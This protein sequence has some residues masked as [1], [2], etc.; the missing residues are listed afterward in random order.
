MAIFKFFFSNSAFGNQKYPRCIARRIIFYIQLILTGKIKFLIC[1]SIS[2]VRQ[3]IFWISKGEPRFF[4]RKKRERVSY[5][6]EKILQ[7]K[8]SS[9]HYVNKYPENFFF[10]SIYLAVRGLKFAALLFYWK[11][12]ENKRGGEFLKNFFV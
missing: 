9:V 2:K 6:E 10:E 12:Q 4:W 5:R 11:R 8:S 3:M 7:Q 1:F